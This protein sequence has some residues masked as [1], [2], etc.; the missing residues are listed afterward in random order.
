ML[1]EFPV[2]HA[3]GNPGGAGGVR[4]AD[5]IHVAAQQEAHGGRQFHIRDR[6]YVGA[7]PRHDCGRSNVYRFRRHGL[8]AQHPVEQLGHFPADFMQFS[9]DPCG[10]NRR[11]L[12]DE[13]VIRIA[14]NRHLFRHL[15]AQRSEH[16][17][18]D[19]EITAVRNQKRD[20]LRQPPEKC[21]Q[22]PHHHAVIGQFVRLEIRL[23][24]ADIERQ[25]MPG[26]DNAERF[27]RIRQ[28]SAAAARPLPRI[29]RGKPGKSFAD[30][31]L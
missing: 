18:G 5:E 3:A 31:I 22:F 27:D 11:I 24:V 17:V 29:D 6:Q 13:G 15:D 21:A 28:E 25:A 19:G 7:A 10:G 1:P 9:V 20:R 2:Q 8:P 30:K 4:N 23:P 26:E 16:A 14:E 12:R